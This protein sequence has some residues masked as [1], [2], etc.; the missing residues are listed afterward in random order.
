MI[1]GT[2]FDFFADFPLIPG[3]SI[4]G[5]DVTLTDLEIAETIVT[6]RELD[7]L[8]QGPGGRVPGRI[9]ERD[10]AGLDSRED[11][12]DA[13]EDLGYIIYHGQVQ[14]PDFIPGAL[15]AA[16]DAAAQASSCPCV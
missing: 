11:Q 15:S 2:G 14:N 1:L 4:Q 16:A 12:L 13:L 10:I 9:T 5:P 7:L 8:S 6:M 3:G